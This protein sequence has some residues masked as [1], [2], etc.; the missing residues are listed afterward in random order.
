MINLK[1]AIRHLLKEKF[2]VTVNLV[3]LTVAMA[4]A[5]VIISF[6]GYHNSFDRHVEGFDRTYRINS[7]ID[8]G[9]FWLLPSLPLMWR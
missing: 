4:V 7:R 9:T 8:N 2:F 5:L 3:G 6:V 1:I